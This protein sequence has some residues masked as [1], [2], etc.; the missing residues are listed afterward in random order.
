MSDELDFND[1]GPQQSFEVIPNATICML[2]MHIRP[3][4]DGGWLTP[5]K[6][7]NSKHLNCEFVVV[8]GEHAKKKLWSRLTVEGVNHA[9][10]IRISNATLRAILESARNIT[11]NDNS[12]EAVAAR[13]TTGW[14]DF[15]GVQFVARLGM[16]P[17]KNGYKAKNTIDEVLTP[18][19]QGWRKPGPPAPASTTT[20]PQPAGSGGALRRPDWAEGKQQ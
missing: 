18:D 10:A 5:S 8:D 15:D 17:P 20:S 6:D 2:Q 11:P 4:N 16:E 7:G 13:R 14:N 3:G 1:A 9:Q 19:R 12:P